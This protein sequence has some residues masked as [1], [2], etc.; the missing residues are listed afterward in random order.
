MIAMLLDCLKTSDSNPPQRS[1]EFYA[2]NNS[3]TPVQEA[4]LSRRSMFQVSG[5]A[6]ASMAMTACPAQADEES[7]A[8]ANPLLIQYGNT[9]LFQGDSITDAGRNQD[10][11]KSNSQPALGNGYAWLAAAQLL[12]DRSSNLRIY[13]RGRGGNGV[14][15]LAERWDADCLTLKPNVVSILIGVNDAWAEFDGSDPKMLDKYKP[16][17]RELLQRTKAALPGVRLVVCEPFLLRCGKV[18]DKRFLGFGRYCHA[19]REI[20]SEEQA[21]IVPF[22]SL[23][24]LASTIAPPE[25]WAIDGVHPTAAGAA[26]MAREWLTIVGALSSSKIV[27][28]P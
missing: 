11:A 21:A 9:I 23:F 3:Y 8:T 28:V 10:D 12:L 6:A 20:A 4:S 5:I 19:A 2:V 18:D 13:N 15:H 16:Q 25:H 14:E 27:A 17:Y 7:C 26:L 1:S 22:Q 24:D